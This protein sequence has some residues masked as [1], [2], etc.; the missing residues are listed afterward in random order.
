MKKVLIT[1]A[2]GG[3][4]SAMAKAFAAEGYEVGVCY[5][6]SFNEARRVSSEIK[7]GGGK[8]QIF[9]ADLSLMGDAENLCEQVLGSMGTPDVVICNAGIDSWGLFQD[10]GEAEW[11]R[12]LDTNLKGSY[13]VT[14]GLLPKMIERKSGVLLYT[15]S[16]WGVV[17]GACEAAY[18]A[19]KGAL[20]SM[21]KALAKELGPSG[22]RV[23]CIAPGLIKT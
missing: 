1:G 15:S 13:A 20:I 12:V 3:I 23:N 14:R 18:S 8:A 22:I 16:I 5:N 11:N 4:G 21:T 17:G 2:S 7:A 9:M 19:S 10:I 6:R